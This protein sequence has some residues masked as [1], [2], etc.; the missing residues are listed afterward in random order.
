MA[1][2]PRPRICFYTRR[3]RHHEPHYQSKIIHAE[4][5]ISDSA[6]APQSALRDCSICHHCHIYGH[7]HEKIPIHMIPPLVPSSPKFSI[8]RLSST[9]ESGSALPSEHPYARARGFQFS[10]LAV[11]LEGPD[12]FYS[13]PFHL[14]VFPPFS[15]VIV[16]V[17]GVPL[18]RNSRPLARVHAFSVGTVEVCTPEDTPRLLPPLVRQRSDTKH[19]VSRDEGQLRLST[20]F[21]GTRYVCWEWRRRKQ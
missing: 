13:H 19:T 14:L 17:F 15:A 12:P 6:R 21:F 1:K 11:S 20:G 16:S 3:P 9:T 8:G 10:A 18:R 2:W 5:S 4:S 7:F